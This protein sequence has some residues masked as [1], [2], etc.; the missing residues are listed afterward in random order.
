MQIYLQIRFYPLLSFP[1]NQ[2]QESGFQKAGGLVRRNIS[3]YCLQRVAL[4]FKA[5]PNS[6][7]FYKGIFLH[8]ISVRIIVPWNMLGTYIIH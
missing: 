8:V 1:T 4:Y 3:V 5:M 7:E 6:I 2:N